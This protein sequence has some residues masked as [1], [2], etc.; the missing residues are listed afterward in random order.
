EGPPAPRCHQPNSGTTSPNAPAPRTRTASAAMIRTVCSA[1][2]E[3]RNSPAAA[4]YSATSS[5]TV[6]AIPHDFGPAAAAHLV[7]RGRGRAR[8]R[9]ASL[10]F[11]RCC[12]DAG[13]VA[14][15]T[16]GP[17]SW[18]GRPVARE[19]E[20]APPPAAAA[21]FHARLPG[22]RPTELLELPVLAE[23]LGV[24]R[25]FV[26][27]ESTRLG[28][29]A[30]KVLGASW[31]VHQILTDSPG[32]PATPTDPASATPPDALA[33]LRT[34]AARHPGLI[35]VTATDGNHGR[36]VARMA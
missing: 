25:V 16:A 10:A 34:A 33:D 35:F 18:Y 7:F 28:L 5:V 1:V 30:F 12:R 8:L 4:R 14:A 9:R 26:K 27:D 20:C 31:A 23:E 11:P 15:A 24:G 29:P 3:R 21:A 6:Q 22:Y 13:R 17:G 2:R 19:W 32:E 36:A